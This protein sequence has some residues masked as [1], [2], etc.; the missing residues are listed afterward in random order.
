MTDLP[1][2]PSPPRR[3]RLR[4]TAIAGLMA[5]LAV[6]GL[7]ESRHAAA[8]GLP[9]WPSGG[10]IRVL[11][12]EPLE[13]EAAEAIYQG[14]L[15]RMVEGYLNSRLDNVDYRGWRRLTP[16]PYA[17][18]EHGMRFVNVYANQAAEGMAGATRE[19]PLPEGAVVAKDSFSVV[20]G[21]ATS[22]GPLFIMEKMPAGFRP[23]AGD[24]RYT[25][26]M[27]NG[28]LFGTTKG[29]GSAAVQYC[30]DCHAKAAASDYLFPPEKTAGAGEPQ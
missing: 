23:E 19:A 28:R 11:D 8:E 29:R 13:P 6:W 10:N 15:D 12:A 5:A 4:G 26:I 7:A 2:P 24:W 27:P 18:D 3:G 14:L 9:Q 22:P 20:R 25:L 21:G 1:F 16:L 30:A 17:S